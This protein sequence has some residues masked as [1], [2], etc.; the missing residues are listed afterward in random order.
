MTYHRSE[1]DVAIL[2][3][4]CFALFFCRGLVIGDVGHMTFFL[5]TMV[6]L[7][8]TIVH[9]FLDLKDRRS[10]SYRIVIAL[11][12]VK[13][14]DGFKN[15]EIRWFTILVSLCAGIQ[16]M[17]R[18]QQ[19]HEFIMLFM[20]FEKIVRTKIFFHCVYWKVCGADSF[21]VDFPLPN[22]FSFPIAK[23]NWNLYSNFVDFWT[24]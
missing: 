8:R 11:I 22:G 2:F 6:T 10:C 24:I 13:N 12:I 5:V 1:S 20:L 3:K 4:C 9:C 17:I 15:C 19:K 21:F 14:L 23:Q 18:I 7:D 16:W